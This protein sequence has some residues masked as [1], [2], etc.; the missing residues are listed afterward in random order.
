METGASK[1]TSCRESGGAKLRATKSGRRSTSTSLTHCDDCGWSRCR[2][3]CRT[4]TVV[5][6]EHDVWS[7]AT[8]RHIGAGH[9]SRS[10]SAET[11]SK[12]SKCR[13]CGGTE[14]METLEVRL[15]SPDSGAIVFGETPV[16]ELSTTLGTTP[17][18]PNEVLI[19]RINL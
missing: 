3:R 12:S 17:D 8:S 9:K 2:C 14:S 16:N 6:T 11:R 1:T 18:W 10:R 13:G 19:L 4:A 7:T 15:L 5:D